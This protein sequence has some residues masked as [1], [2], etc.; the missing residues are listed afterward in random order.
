MLTNLMIAGFGGQGVLFMGKIFAHTALLEEKEVSWLPSYGPEMRGGTANCSICVDDEPI[1]C[2]IVIEP[3]ILIAM[4][5]PSFDKFIG[6]VKPNGCVIYDSSLIEK[7]A[8]RSDIVCRAIPATELATQH[9]LEGLAN[10]ILLGHTLK[11]VQFAPYQT[12]C[13]AMKACVPQSKKHLLTP[14]LKALELGYTFEA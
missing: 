13:D 12:V 6:R 10:I 14:N 3:D 8:D 5:V 4:N 11:A 7:E 1:G 2:P 9:H